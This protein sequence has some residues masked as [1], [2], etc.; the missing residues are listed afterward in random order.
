MKLETNL[1]VADY[2]YMDKTGASAHQSGPSKPRGCEKLNQGTIKPPLLPPRNTQSQESLCQATNQPIANGGNASIMMQT[3]D[4]IQ[5]DPSPPKPHVDLDMSKHVKDKTISSSP[6]SNQNAF[7]NG[8]TNKK[9]SPAA[10]VPNLDDAVTEHADDELPVSEM[11]CYNGIVNTYLI[12]AKYV[13]RKGG[14]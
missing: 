4:N 11:Y 5:G 3:P 1:P 9:E 13:I 2:E 12:H 8:I 14:M 6:K 10:P 7:L